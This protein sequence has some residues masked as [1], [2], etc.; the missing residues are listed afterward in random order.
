MKKILHTLAILAMLA[1]SPAARADYPDRPITLLVLYTAGGGADLSAR[2][3]AKKVE[4][5]LGQPVM[6]VNKVG[7]SGSLAVGAIAAAKPDGY[8][9]GVTSTAG[10]LTFAPHMF[11]VPY[12]PLKDFDHIMGYG[13]YMFGLAVRADSPYKTL[14]D[15][16]QFAQANPGKIKYGALGVAIINNFV[17]LKLAEAEG[18]KWDVVVFKGAPESVAALLGGHVDAVLQNPGDVVEYIKAGRLRLLASFSEQRWEWVP[19]VPTSREL[20]YKFHFYTGLGLA[21]PKGVPKPV[22]A[23]LRDAFKKTMDDPEFLEIMKRIYVT[24]AYQTPEQF[25]K[26]VE[27]DYKDNG[28]MIMR[29]GL[30][31]SQQKK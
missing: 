22:M 18:I 16:T 14:K 11:D 24:V 28:A 23:K 26:R 15:L 6:V 31:K 21:A 12:D 9:I 2:A 7:A 30:H 25:Q 20:G 13:E 17:M 29:L 3:L 5:Y 8:T 1:F 4:K 27:A 19:D 10:P